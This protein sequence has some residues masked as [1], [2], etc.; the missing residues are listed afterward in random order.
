MPLK[1][2]MLDDEPDIC[3]IF[4]DNFSTVDI[5]IHT[6]NDPKK[7]LEA[8]HADPPDLL[9][10]DYRLPNTNGVEVARAIKIKIPMALLTG[11]LEVTSVEIF[12]K[13]FNKQPFPW[14]EI[15]SYLTS[16]LNKKTG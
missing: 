13:K 3:Q 11:D 9:F 4:K 10:F 7:F 16:H 15:E 8:I 12:E 5:T 1:V 14:I 2:Y 6:F